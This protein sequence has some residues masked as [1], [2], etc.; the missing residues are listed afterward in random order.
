[1]TTDTRSLPDAV[2]DASAGNALWAWV[3]AGSL[4]IAGALHVVAAA[5]HLGAGDLVVGFFLLVA[6]VQLA[7]GVRL[8]VGA[9]T[10]TGLPVWSV[11][12]ALALT[13]G[14]LLLYLVAHTTDLLAGIADL[15]HHGDATSPA[16]GTAHVE[17]PEPA[18]P[19]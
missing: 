16:H 10:R 19:V 2:T 5:D 1:M 3:A 9:L 7:V 8:A 14:L 12:G 13:V 15:D 17:A 4:G 6:V 18:G 11:A